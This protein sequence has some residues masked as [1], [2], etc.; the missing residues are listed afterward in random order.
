MEF[1][2]LKKRKMGLNKSNGN[3]YPWITH[4]WNIVKGK[5]Y[6]DCAYCYMKRFGA[7]K[8]VRFDEKELK[9]FDRDM[10]K[11]GQG[12]FIF[13]GSSCDMFAPDVQNSW[14]SRALTHLKKYD[15]TY[16]FQSKNPHGFQH[17]KFPEKTRLCTTIESNRHY[18][19]VM[20]NSIL[21]EYR[22]RHF[23]HIKTYPKYITIEPILDFDLDELINLIKINQPVQ[24]NIGADSQGHNLPEPSK[25]QIIDLV[26]GLK[27]FTKVELK[28]NLNRIL[29][30]KN[31]N[32]NIKY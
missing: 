6:H 1:T 32:K 22:A 5:C 14:I 11:F 24:V 7:Q 25:D 13:A 10:E 17:F 8:P 26:H 15:N 18:P 28:S 19:N 2:I 23:S 20:G 21:P 3:M 27:K 16:L 30:I 9:E 4:T 29:K 12:L 31:A